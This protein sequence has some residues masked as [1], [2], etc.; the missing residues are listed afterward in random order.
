MDLDL[1]RPS[2][3]R[4]YHKKEAEDHFSITVLRLSTA[5]QSIIK[6]WSYAWCLYSPSPAE[7]EFG[8]IQ[9]PKRRSICLLSWLVEMVEISA[10]DN[11]ETLLRYFNMFSAD[12][13][14]HLCF[15]VAKVGYFRKKTN[16]R[17]LFFHRSTP[18]YF[19]SPACA[20]LTTPCSKPVA[21]LRAP[22]YTV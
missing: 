11:I 6:K 22:F 15:A 20:L 7:T 4:R 18:W 9:R 21:G 5:H 10:Q 1:P 16:I 13:L 12:R 8:Y 3:D 17:W 2:T 14:P 19:L